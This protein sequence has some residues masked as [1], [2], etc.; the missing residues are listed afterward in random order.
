MSGSRPYGRRD[1]DLLSLEDHGECGAHSLVSNLPVGV[2]SDVHEITSCREGQAEVFHHSE[3]YVNYGKLLHSKPSSLC[4]LPLGTVSDQPGRENYS[5]LQVCP[6]TNEFSQ[7]F[8][9]VSSSQYQQRHDACGKK[10]ISPLHLDQQGSHGRW[11]SSDTRDCKRKEMMEFLDFS[12]ADD[13]PARLPAISGVLT[14]VVYM[15][16]CV[17]IVSKMCLMFSSPSLI[18]KTFSLGS[19][20]GKA[21]LLCS[22]MFLIVS[23]MCLCFVKAC[24]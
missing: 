8:R 17:S 13:P 14:E 9:C 18:M 6:K 16:V 4:S 23:T 24:A 3:L 19:T 11:C 1:P 2:C 20:A 21:F 22:S 10:A 5:S 7:A 15:C 12:E